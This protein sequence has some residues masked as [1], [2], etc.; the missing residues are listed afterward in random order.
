MGAPQAIRPR[1]A[2]CLDLAWSI[3]PL[4]CATPPQTWLPPS[5]SSNIYQ[6]KIAK[7]ELTSTFA[8]STTVNRRD[9]AAAAGAGST[10]MFT[11]QQNY[12]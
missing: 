9:E 8:I 1:F 7:A 10:S 5:T 12:R 11:I 6:P 4:S 3:L 2:R